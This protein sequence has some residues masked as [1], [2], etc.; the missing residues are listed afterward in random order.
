MITRDVLL[1]AVDDGAQLANVCIRI[2]QYIEFC[3]QNQIYAV[4]TDS[5]RAIIELAVEEQID[6]NQ[7]DIVTFLR[8][9]W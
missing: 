1:K 9:A 6:E 3:E 7:P 4:G 5:L 8:K 2:C